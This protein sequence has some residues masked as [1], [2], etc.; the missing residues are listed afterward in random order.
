M[1][2]RR[3]QASY[4]SPAVRGIERTK[5]LRLCFPLPMCRFFTKFTFEK[6]MKDAI[7]KH[8]RFSCAHIE[9]APTLSIDSGNFYRRAAVYHDVSHASSKA[10]VNVIADGSKRR[11]AS[12][13][14]GVV[15]TRYRHCK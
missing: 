1:A 7:V 12:K 6:R 13:Q 10:V 4:A 11:E 9:Q 3:L 8:G 2:L 15:K 14:A 5:K